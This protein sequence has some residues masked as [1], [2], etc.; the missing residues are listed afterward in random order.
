MAS[1]DLGLPEELMIQASHL[2]HG[3][4]LNGIVS[5]IERSLVSNDK[6]TPSEFIY[7]PQILMGKSVSARMKRES[8]DATNKG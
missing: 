4:S 5:M 2:S 3:M 7:Y 1:H 6:V 8:I